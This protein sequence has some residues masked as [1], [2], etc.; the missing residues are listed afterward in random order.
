MQVS[1]KLTICIFRIVFLTPSHTKKQAVCSNFHPELTRPEEYMYT[2]DQEAPSQ[3]QI[4]IAIPQ[5]LNRVKSCC[6]CQ[7]LI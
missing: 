7:N 2:Q 1:R 5:E 3:V 4:P 6:L